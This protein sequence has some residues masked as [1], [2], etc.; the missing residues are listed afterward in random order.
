MCTLGELL[1]MNEQDPGEAELEA[2]VAARH[3]GRQQ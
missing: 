2:L 3:S 1:S